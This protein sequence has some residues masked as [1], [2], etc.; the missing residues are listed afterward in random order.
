MKLIMNIVAVLFI[1][2]AF[3][4]CQKAND[5]VSPDNI[6]KSDLNSTGITST[7]YDGS[8]EVTFKNY[9]N[10]QQTTTLKGTINFIF[11]KSTYSYFGEISNTSEEPTT[12]TIH[13]IGT[14]TLNGNIIS[15]ADDAAKMEHAGWM[16]SLYLSG[17]YKYTHT[18]NLTVIEGNGRFGSIKITLK[19]PA[20]EGQ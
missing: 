20:T 6:N 1:S 9:K 8:F 14:Y 4:A 16:P 3:A 10:T 2:I 11:D 18:G 13:D 5:P 15:L 17:D 7:G 12:I 19:A